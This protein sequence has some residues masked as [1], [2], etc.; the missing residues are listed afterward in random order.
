M[1][2]LYDFQESDV[3]RFINEPT[4]A[5]LNASVVG[6]GKTLVASEIIRRLQFRKTLVIAP[7]NTEDGWRRHA[8]EHLGVQMRRIGGT[9]ASDK[10]DRELLLD[11]KCDGI[12]FATWEQAR[13]ML[14]VGEEY[15]KVK[16]KMVPI[17]EPLL[18][19]YGSGVDFIVAD[20]VHRAQNRQADSSKVLVSLTKAVFKEQEEGRVLAMSAT[21]AGNRLPGM[22]GTLRALWPEKY[23][24]GKGRGYGPWW[25]KHFESVFNK[26]SGFDEPG[27]ELNPGSVVRDIPSYWRPEQGYNCCEFQTRGVQED[28]PPVVEHQ[29]TVE[30]SPTQRRIYEDIK[31]SAFAWVAEH[32]WPIE[33]KGLPTLEFLR[34]CQV[35]LGV[36]TP[37]MITVLRRPAGSPVDAE[38]VEQEILKLR[39]DDDFKSSKVDAL[40]DIVED[41]PGEERFMVYTHSTAVIPAVVARLRAKGIAAERWDG[42]VSGDQRDAVKRRFTE[43]RTRCIVAQI[44]AIGEGV[45][46]LQRVCSNEIWF[47]SSPNS[48]HNIQCKGRLSRTGQT[49]AVNR[50]TILAKDTVELEHWWS[51][52]AADRTLHTALQG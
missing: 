32:E 10:R 33:T 40:L 29:V 12:F 39:F 5:G 42:T 24:T 47:S 43:G 13:Q 25:R 4:Y 6:V 44:A 3:Q 7:L 11:P 27:D 49:R 22:W 31:D 18:S 8:D 15:D 17:K 38:K 26:W 37:E 28:L 48:M 52:T 21:P 9:K 1:F 45:D 34:L 35:C 36:P 20:E 41:I 30:L 50:W 23:D 2:D 16:D 19:L 14:V 51:Q 46:G